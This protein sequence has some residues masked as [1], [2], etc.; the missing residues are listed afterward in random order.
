MRFW[1]SKC[2]AGN[3]KHSRF[4]G[5]GWAHTSPPTEPRSSERERERASESEREGRVNFSVMTWRKR[6]K[7]VLLLNLI[8]QAYDTHTHT[9]SHILYYPSGPRGQSVAQQSKVSYCITNLILCCYCGSGA[10]HRIG[11]LAAAWELGPRGPAVQRRC[12]QMF[13]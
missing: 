12:A 4:F 3:Q 13:C 6:V 10:V 9:I 8:L 7:I 11:R 1:D 5:L 2:N